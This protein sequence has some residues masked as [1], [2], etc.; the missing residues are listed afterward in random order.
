MDSHFWTLF[1]VLHFSDIRKTNTNRGKTTRRNIASTPILSHTKV[2]QRKNRDRRTAAIQN[3]TA[4][5]L[6]SPRTT[7]VVLVVVTI[8]LTVQRGNIQSPPVAMSDQVHWI[9]TLYFCSLG[10]QPCLFQCFVM[11][12]SVIMCACTYTSPQVVVCIHTTLTER[13]VNRTMLT[14]GSGVYP[15]HTH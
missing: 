11:N 6:R 12:E 9:G 10:R 3:L 1:P 5:L 8:I 14:T 15:Y 2:Y 13:R 7:P 4:L